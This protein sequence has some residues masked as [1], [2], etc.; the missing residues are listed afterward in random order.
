MNYTN[1][2]KTYEQAVALLDKYLLISKPYGEASSIY[3]KSIDGSIL[4]INKNIKYHISK[5][6]FKEHFNFAKFFIYKDLNEV[7]IDQE[8]H[9]LRQ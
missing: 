3:A 4:V 2:I 6:E 9:N 7:E 1:E 8:F 5:N